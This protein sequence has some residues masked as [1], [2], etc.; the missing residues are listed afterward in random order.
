M[1]LPQYK[2]LSRF[3]VTFALLT[4]FMLPAGNVFAAETPKWL[5]TKIV[6]W[7]L[8][9]SGKSMG[10][11]G[12][13]NLFVKIRHTNNSKDRVIT[14][15]YDKKGYFE[16]EGDSVEVRARLQSSKVNRVNVD[17][18]ESFNLTYTLPITECLN[19]FNDI[20]A[21][22]H[23]LSGSIK[24]FKIRKWGYTVGVKSEGI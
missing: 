11:M 22:N 4:A 21:M 19:N 8:L 20:S 18:G 23:R 15:F 17:P 3:F 10:D 6:E 9:K 1:T 24:Y 14:A 12:A 2:Q 13:M 5:G 16:I 7:K